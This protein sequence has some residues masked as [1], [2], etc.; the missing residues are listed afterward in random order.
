LAF[1]FFIAINIKFP[2]NSAELH[3][4]LNETAKN[5]ESVVT[6]LIENNKVDLLKAQE[7]IEDFGVDRVYEIKDNFEGTMDP[8]FKNKTKNGII[9][10]IIGVGANAMKIIEEQAMD[11]NF[12]DVYSFNTETV[13]GENTTK[14]SSPKRG[15]YLEKYIENYEKAVRTTNEKGSSP[16][17]NEFGIF[18]K[19]ASTVSDEMPVASTVSDEMPVA[20]TV[21]DEMPVASTV[22]DEMPVASTVSDEMPVA[23]EANIVK[24][25][26]SSTQKRM[27]P[28]AQRYLDAANKRGGSKTRGQKRKI[29]ESKRKSGGSKKQKRRS[30][31]RK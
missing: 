31:K 20:S 2:Q 7:I 5:P 11:I 6:D 16:K 23:S 4:A 13:A 30:H 15:K 3:E 25:N 18:S 1:V 12:G 26:T 28:L 29:V 24:E 21:S 27:S 22:S 19:V 9:K 17:R 8:I 10:S 14:T